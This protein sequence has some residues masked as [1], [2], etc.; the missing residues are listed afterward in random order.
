MSAA[1]A[2]FA[3]PAGSAFQ[4]DDGDNGHICEDAYDD[5]LPSFVDSAE[6][7]SEDV[8]VHAPEVVAFLI[9]GTGDKYRVVEGAEDTAVER[10]DAGAAHPLLTMRLRGCEA[11]A[12]AEDAAA[13][14]TATMDTFF[15]QPVPPCC[16]MGSHLE[17]NSRRMAA[18]P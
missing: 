8:R 10:V 16:H 7:R 2:A 4:D 9:G 6:E 12:P 15:V 18:I 13:M 1:A 3:R 11:R 17:L 14:P 5:G